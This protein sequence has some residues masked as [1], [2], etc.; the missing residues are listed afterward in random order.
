MSSA[1]ASA[2]LPLDPEFTLGA[3]APEDAARRSAL[4]LFGLPQQDQRWLLERLPAAE[5]ER[6]QLLLDELREM[7]IAPDRATAM[8]LLQEASDR[9]PSPADSA[10]HAGSAA[11]VLRRVDPAR[12]ALALKD[13]PTALLARLLAGQSADWRRTFL[14]QVPAAKRVKLAAATGEP[15]SQP[16]PALAP[17][18]RLDAAVLR[19][20]AEIAQSAGLVPQHAVLPV[21]SPASPSPNAWV[22]LRRWMSRETPSVIKESAR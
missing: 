11:A 17:A 4:L 18:P 16:S 1:Q 2:V 7:G 5:R 21:H 10:G 13:E 8:R 6:L 19:V 12:L 20:V 14:T 3:S 15:H 9:L 22:R